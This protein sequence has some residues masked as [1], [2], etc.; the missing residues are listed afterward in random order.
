MISSYSAVGLYERLGFR[1][2]PRHDFDATAHFG[3]LGVDPVCT[4]AYR[5]NLADPTEIGSRYP[6]ASGGTRMEWQSRQIR[7]LTEERR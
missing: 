7:L 4:L 1:R 3:S 5:L 6:F 2:A